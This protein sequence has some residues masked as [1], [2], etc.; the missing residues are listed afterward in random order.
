[1]SRLILKILKFIL[2]TTE[3]LNPLPSGYSNTLILQGKADAFTV[4]GAK[5][6]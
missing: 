6:I 4:L 3:R 1:M 5:T 2:P